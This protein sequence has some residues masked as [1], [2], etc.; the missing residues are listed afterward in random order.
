MPFQLKNLSKNHT[1]PTSAKT[2]PTPKPR[3]RKNSHKSGMKIAE[4]LQGI[5]QGVV[6]D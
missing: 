4:D 1:K 6:G 2:I 3:T 5:T